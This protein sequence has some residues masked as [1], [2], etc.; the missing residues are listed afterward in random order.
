MKFSEFHSQPQVKSGPAG[1]VRRQRSLALIVASVMALAGATFVLV[2]HQHRGADRAL[3]ATARANAMARKILAAFL[4]ARTPEERAEYVLDGERLLPVMQA[5]YA[6]REVEPLAADEFRPP[7]WQ[8][9]AGGQGLVA[10]E[11]PRPRGLSTVAACFKETAPNRWLMDWDLWTQSIE[12]RFRN[13]V[14]RAAEGEYTMHVRL[15]ASE[16]GASSVKLQVA[17]PFNPAESLNVTVTRSDLVGLYTAA[18]PKGRSRTATVQ[19]VWLNDS[20]TGTLV[21]G[22]QRHICWGFRGFDEGS[23]SLPANPAPPADPQLAVLP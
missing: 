23:E 15:T 2:R 5:Y 3:E 17:D 20:L 13:F 21:P 14:R 12:A 4:A 10:L 8:F 16:P 18:L 6:G 7:S 11:L 19:L 22:L 9:N 1:P